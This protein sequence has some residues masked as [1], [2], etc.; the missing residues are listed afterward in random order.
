MPA[1]NHRLLSEKEEIMLKTQAGL[2]KSSEECQEQQQE[3]IDLRLIS[4]T[5]CGICTYNHLQQLYP[6]E[7]CILTYCL[8]L[9]REISFEETFVCVRKETREI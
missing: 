8:N 7:E 5:C 3:K 4:L 2:M 9:I 6:A 1:T